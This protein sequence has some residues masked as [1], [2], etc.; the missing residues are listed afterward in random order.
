MAQ[1]VGP[2]EVGE[3]PN[4][5]ER[6]VATRL[7]AQLPDNVIVYHSQRRLT[8][9]DN[10][11]RI[12]LAEGEIDLIVVDPASGVLVIEVKGGRIEYDERRQRYLQHGRTKTT[13][14]DPFTQASK[15][16]HALVE[17][18]GSRLGGVNAINFPYGF[19]VVFP[20]CIFRGPAPEQFTPEIILSDPDLEFLDRRIPDILKRYR[21]SSASLPMTREM[22]KTVRDVISPAM[23]LSQPIAL[24]VSTQEKELLRM[25]ERQA[26]V[27]QIIASSE[28]I[29]INGVAG[30]GKTLLA[31]EQARRLAR[32]GRLVAIVCY[33]NNLEGE[34]QTKVRAPSPFAR[35][36]SLTDESLTGDDSPDAVSSS[37]ASSITVRTFH[38]LARE[39]AERAG[40]PFEIPSDPEEA[41]EFWK[42]DAAAILFD[43]ADC[44]PT[45][46]YD[47]ILVDEGQDFYRDW[48]DALE[49]LLTPAV[50]SEQPQP[51]LQVFYDANQNLYVDDSTE[52]H[53]P[54]D[55]V[56]IR[57]P[58]NCRNTKTIAAHCG[59]VLD[60]SIPT[61]DEA[62][63]GTV[64]AIESAD[65]PA[66]HRG[67][68]ADWI[69][70]NVSASDA[71]RLQPRQV[72]VLSPFATSRTVGGLTH[73]GTTRVTHSLRDW[74][75]NAGVLVSTIRSF[76]G[77]EADAVLLV[78][79]VPPRPG[80]ALTTNDLY[81]ASSRAKH[82]LTIFPTGS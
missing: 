32:A 55:L 66:V 54:K 59:E 28:R 21:R 4:T 70:A 56:S 63:E 81:V 41:R 47:A 34:I 30:S 26:E 9:S 36:E 3:I 5:G 57:L 71:S 20:H 79:I 22:T 80:S 78:D 31:V 13:T 29:A 82:A 68:V 10:G 40:L 52:K 64:V 12:P 61:R 14:I 76:K 46:R 39:I 19:A 51:R 72:A 65:D 35:G 58:T 11:R 50:S 42:Q 77:L 44:V 48:F 24:A 75:E 73:L 18:I 49:K 43:A 15:N 60:V 17:A 67:R 25:T 33:N 45:L 6:D 23:K 2:T 7:V 62:P 69:D 38:Q 1:F 16:L 74:R 37:S 53:L 27:L 8:N